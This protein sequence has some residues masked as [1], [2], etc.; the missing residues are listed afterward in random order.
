MQMLSVVSEMAGA[1]KT[2]NQDD[3]S[4]IDRRGFELAT[5][6]RKIVISVVKVE[7]EVAMIAEGRS[8]TMGDPMQGRSGPGRRVH[9]GCLVLNDV[10]FPKPYR[11]PNT[12]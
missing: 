6:I 3:S 1:V 2:E 4:E 7:V 12:T 8:M 10:T 9:D 5:R 11:L